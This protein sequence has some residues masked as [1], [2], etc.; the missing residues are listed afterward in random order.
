VEEGGRNDP[1]MYA[2]VNK[3]KI[4]KKRRVPSAHK[5]PVLSYGG[6]YMPRNVRMGLGVS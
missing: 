4:K 6:A 1:N 3:I 2:H 5:L